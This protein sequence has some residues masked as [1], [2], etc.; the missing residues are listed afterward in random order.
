VVGE[1]VIRLKPLEMACLAVGGGQ[2]RDIG[3]SARLRLTSCA[4]WVGAHRNPLPGQEIETPADQR[5]VP[6]AT[7]TEDDVVSQC[8]CAAHGHPLA[9]V[10]LP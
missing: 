5:R 1:A 2:L 7:T 10:P 8:R 6:E 4:T 9:S 3:G